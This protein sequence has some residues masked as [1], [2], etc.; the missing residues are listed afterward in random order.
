MRST[1]TR[2]IVWMSRNCDV[3]PMHLIGY[4][5]L[6]ADTL[7]NI[8][9]DSFQA[10]RG[11]IRNVLEDNANKSLLADSEVLWAWCDTIL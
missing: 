2:W 8:R 1:I 7:A 9:S 5:P 10:Q 3:A 4:A 11:Y 6:F